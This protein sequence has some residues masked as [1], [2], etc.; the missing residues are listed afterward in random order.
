MVI[1][2]IRKNIGSFKI[3]VKTHSIVSFLYSSKVLSIGVLSIQV[4]ITN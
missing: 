3:F 2:F 1:Y 4:E